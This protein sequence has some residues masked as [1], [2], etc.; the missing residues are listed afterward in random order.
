MRIEAYHRPASL[1]EVF[2]LLREDGE[3]RLVAGGTDLLVRRGAPARTLIS[4]R[5]VVELRG[6]GIRDTG[7][8]GVGIRG[9]GAA[10]PVADLASH[11]DLAA[12]Y[13]VLVQAARRLGSEQI[14][15]VAT[16]GGNLCRAA[17]CA[18][19]AP[20]LLVLEARAA[21][22]GPQG[23]R[24]V[25]VEDFFTGPGE[26][27]LGP[28]EVLTAVH[29]DPPRPGAVGLFLKKGR[30]RMDLSIASVALLLEADGGRCR[31]IRI[32]A[33][34]VAPRPIRL[35][36]VEALLEG[37]LLDGPRLEEAARLASATVAPITDIRSTEAY[38]RHVVGVYVRRAIERIL[39]GDLS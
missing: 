38:R 28:G 3:A 2:R 26:T 9:I 39:A 36:E 7:I 17:P 13:P 14:R 23:T 22:Q 27:C 18:D 32:A 29:L 1:A 12:H 24:E 33:G 30:V 37:A 15:S 35:R 31:R 4:L 16:L 11:P 20:P 8:G 10:T 5:G 19:L 21:I 25:G 34:S 6:I